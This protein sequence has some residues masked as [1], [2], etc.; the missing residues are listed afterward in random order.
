MNIF[1][2]DLNH[3]KNAQYHCDKHVCKMLVE[4]TQ[5]LCSAYYFTDQAHLSPYRLTHKNHPC[6]VWVRE[7]LD[8]WV[9]LY[10]LSLKLYDEYKHRYGDKIHKAGE[11][12]KALPI[13]CLMP[14]GLTPFAQAMPTQYKCIDTVKAYRNYYLGDKQELFSWKNRNRPEW[15]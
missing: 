2:L 5:L 7:S 10:C 8:N 1:V 14:K 11:T 15:T 6:A 13:P 12:I 9:W 4:Y 3:T